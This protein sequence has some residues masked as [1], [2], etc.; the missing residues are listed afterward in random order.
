MNRLVQHWL[1][2]VTDAWDEMRH[3]PAVN[4]LAAAT[5]TASLFVA[6]LAVL[7]IT[8]VGRHVDQLQSEIRIDVFLRDDAAAEAIA[9]LQSQLKVTPGVERV[10]HVSKDEALSRYH[11]W[12]REMAQLI[13]ELD[14]NPLPASLEVYLRSD[15]DTEAIGVSIAD[16]F[17]AH[18]A[19]DDLRFDR[20][21]IARLESMLR[22]A[23]LAGIVLVGVV[24]AAVV[25]VVSSVLR[26]AVYARRDEIEIMQLVG[27]TPAFVRG[28]FLV[29]GSWFGLG[30]G[31][32]ALLVV[33]IVRQF[34]LSYSTRA[35]LPLLRLFCAQPVSSGWVLGLVLLGL[36][37]GV[38]GSWFAARHRF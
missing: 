20:D 33:E 37:V 4:L 7:V 26:L 19:V 13:G 5:L 23:R 30:G 1:F 14:D 15:Q 35:S 3:S 6:G 10:L 11:E 38:A 9:E 12:S 17:G 25:F 8:N 22:V 29:A 36:V 2:F 21:W 34:V 27:A 16:S 28:P 32:M 18:V 31:V 24:L